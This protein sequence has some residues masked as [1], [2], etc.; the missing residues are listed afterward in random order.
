MPRQRIGIRRPER[1]SSQAVTKHGL[2]MLLG[3]NSVR[4]LARHRSAVRR[5]AVRA[6][7]WRPRRRPVRRGAIGREPSAICRFRV[8]RRRGGVRETARSFPP[9]DRRVACERPSPSRPPVPRDLLREPS[10]PPSESAWRDL[11]VAR[12]VICG[13][14]V[15]STVV[16]GVRAA[17]RLRAPSMECNQISR[18]LGK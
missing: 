5:R 1:S 6:K 13:A 18:R 12:P 16:P 4:S 3:K 8:G 14:P 15:W 7:C 11:R 9:A 17:G 10:A 2:P